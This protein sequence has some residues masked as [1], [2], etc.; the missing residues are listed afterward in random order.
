MRTLK[1]S[2]FIHTLDEDG[3]T[4]PWLAKCEDEE[5]IEQV[6][7]KL[8]DRKSHGN[9]DPVLNEYVAN[10][11]AHELEIEAPE[12][13]LVEFSSEDLAI[14][15]DKQRA[16]LSAQ[17]SDSSSFKCFATR[18]CDGQIIP[19]ES[20]TDKVI[21]CNG[22]DSVFAFDVLTINPDRRVNKPN[23]LVHDDGYYVIDHEQCFLFQNKSYSELRDSIKD[24][25]FITNGGSLKGEYLLVKKLKLKRKRESNLDFATFVELFRN[26][27][28][29]SIE[30]EINYLHEEGLEL[31]LHKWTDI[32]K[33]IQDAQKDISG[34]INLLNRLLES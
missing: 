23:L 2:E 34:F 27:K 25:Y 19:P 11:L 12:C 22:Y 9:E 28:V 26:L 15:P 20:I 30:K 3:T 13:F 7:V 5:G 8:F 17:F 18:Y 6:V 31:N 32:K 24:W 1:F 29:E 16:R 10:L 33:Y 21:D 4:A 14:L